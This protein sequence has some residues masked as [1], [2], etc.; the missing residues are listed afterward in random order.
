MD[1]SLWTIKQSKDVEKSRKKYKSN[2]P[3][4]DAFDKAI[5]MLA[6]EKDPAA[7]AYEKT[8]DDTCILR[9]TRAVRM[10]YWMD[11]ETKT[12]YLGKLGDHKEAYG[13]D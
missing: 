2:K 3:V 10:S 1:A 4:C 12:I 5:E 7:V 9:L 6:S 11:D 8:R 13:W